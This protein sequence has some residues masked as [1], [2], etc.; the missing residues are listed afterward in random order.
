MIELLGTDKARW[1]S[2]PCQEMI[3]YLENMLSKDPAPLTVAEVGVGY[4]ATAVE[5]VKRLRKGDAYYFYSFQEDVDALYE[6]LQKQS[7]CKCNLVPLGNTH[8]IYDSFCWNLGKQVSDPKNKDGLY[9]LVYLDGAHSFLLSGLA[10]AL[11]KTLIRDGGY[12]IFDDLNWSFGSSPDCN[13]KV[14]PD[15]LKRFTREQVDTFQIQ[16]VVDVFMKNDK[17]WT[18]EKTTERRAVYQK[19]KPLLKRIFG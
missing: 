17:H 4:G 10:C 2:E 5:I 7:Y 18:C 9:D 11:L 8:A 16:M 13:P 6:D 12:L 14:R 15:I 1:I 19:K 3:E